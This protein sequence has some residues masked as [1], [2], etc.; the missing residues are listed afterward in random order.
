MNDVRFDGLTK[1]LGIGISRRR[2]L[3]GLVGGMATA[4]LPGGSQAQEAIATA[5]ECRARGGSVTYS[6]G[7]FDSGRNRCV[8]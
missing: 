8:L 1:A 7:K 5:A 6:Y 4:A 2:V 3:A